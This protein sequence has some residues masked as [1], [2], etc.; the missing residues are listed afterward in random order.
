[1]A[2]K[3]TM[4]DLAQRAGVS[5]ATVSRALADSPRVKLATRTRIQRLAQELGYSP[6]QLARSIRVQRTQ[7]IGMIIP[8]ILNPF[9]TSL[10]RAIED[11]AKAQH[12]DVVIVNTDEQPDAERDAIQLLQGKRVDGLLIASTDPNQD[13]DRLL[14]ATPTV[15]VDRA[16]NGPITYDRL[17]VDNVAGTQR[18]IANLITR[19]A[20]RIGIIN[21]SASATATERLQGYRQALLNHGLPVDP[22]IIV[23]ARKDNGNVQQMTR[24][25]LQNQKCDALFAADNTILLEVLHKLPELTLSTYFISGFDD[26]DWLNFVSPAITTAK[27]PIQEIGVAALNRLLARIA[28]HHLLPTEKRF[29]PGLVVR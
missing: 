21:S 19:G 10:I 6:N 3:L 11:A 2:D 18:V 1:M 24:Q 26:N 27:Q 14:G 16:P 20:R 29:Q 5:E 4:K 25:L 9:F 7:T 8:N 13:Y 17:L 23:S 22:D 15:F 28:N 12:Y